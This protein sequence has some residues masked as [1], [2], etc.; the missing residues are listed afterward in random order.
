MKDLKIVFELGND[1]LRWKREL[2]S[3][4]GREEF[5]EAIEIRNKLRKLEMQRD[6][7]DALYETSRYEDMI[8]MA[9]PS[10][11]QLRRAREMEDADKMRRLQ[12][13]REKEESEEQARLRRLQEMDEAER[14]RRLKDEE[15]ERKRKQQED[16]A[17]RKNN[18]G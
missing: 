17:R 10:S 4:V 1:I 7:Y 2:E 13:L 12:M 16:A 5:E 9:R 3:A 6:Q 14:M 11:A 8:V 15:E 18:N